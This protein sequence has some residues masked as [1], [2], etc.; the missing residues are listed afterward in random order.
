MQSY[1]TRASIEAALHLPLEHRI[2][3]L[4]LKRVEQWRA[5]GVLDMTHVLVIE[6]GGTEAA[7][8]EEVGFSPLIDLG[9]ARYPSADFDPYWDGP[10][11]RHDGWFELI[12]TVGNS[13]FAFVLFIQD[14][15]GTLPDLLSMCRDHAEPNA[16]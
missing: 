8:I 12:V 11:W 2:H 6:P 14:A 16:A 15:A 13:G 5:A 10:I 3:R 7:I 4:L 1:D 9:G